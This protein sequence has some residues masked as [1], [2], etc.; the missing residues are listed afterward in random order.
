MIFR[1]V[2]GDTIQNWRGTPALSPLPIS[3]SL[4]NPWVIIIVCTS[5]TNRL[6]IKEN[7][8][9]SKSLWGVWRLGIFQS[10]WLKLDQNG[11]ILNL[12][13]KYHNFTRYIQQYPSL[14]YLSL[15]NF[16]VVILSMLPYYWACYSIADLIISVKMYIL[17]TESFQM[18][19][20]SS[21]D[22]AFTL[23]CLNLALRNWN[24]CYVCFKVSCHP[25]FRALVWSWLKTFGFENLL[26]S[27][28]EK[29]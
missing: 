21:Y 14:T 19:K 28:K 24:R 12:S 22:D 18:E 27:W 7:T 2:A 26:V 25:N 13:V 15:S 10:Y 1:K 9:R 8:S 11:H 29:S 4:W 6:W 23:Q 16:S 3:D 17:S 5:N 20:L